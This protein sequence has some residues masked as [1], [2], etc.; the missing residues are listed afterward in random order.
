MSSP[1]PGAPGDALVGDAGMAIVERLEIER[2][3]EAFA[4]ARLDSSGL[5]QGDF[6]IRFSPG[7]ALDAAW[8]ERQFADNA[9]LGKPVPLDRIAALVQELSLA[10]VRNGYVNS[11]LL[12]APA[13]QLENGAIVLRLKL[14]SGRIAGDGR[15]NG[16]LVTWAD[17]KARGLTQGYVAAR[18]PAARA[19]PLDG[20]A[21]E[22][23][24]R[25]LANDPAIETVKADLLPGAS[26]GEARLSVLVTPAP[27]FE[28]Y[29]GI[30]NDRAPSV[31]GI[32]YAAGFAMRNL[33]AP[34]DRLAADGGLTAG[35]PDLSL[36]FRTPFATPGLALVLRGSANRAAV[37]DAPL[38][39]LAIRA[40]D[41]SVEGGIA[42]TLYARPLSPAADSGGAEISERSLVLGARYLHRETQTFLL[43][44][45][46]S[47]SPGSVNGRAAYDAAKVSLDWTERSGRAAWLFGLAATVGIDGT[48]SDVAGIPNPD[49]HFLTVVGQASHARRLGESGFELRARITG[50]ISNGP[51]YSGERFSAGGGQ[52]VRGY[53]EN[54]LLAD[55]G[56]FGSLELARPVRLGGGAKGPLGLEWGSFTPSLF[57][58][59]AAVHNRDTDLQP[60]PNAIASIGAALAWT[61]SPRLAARVSYG[62]ALTDVP[63]VGSRDLQDDGISFALT[64][65]V[66]L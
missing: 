44:I 26:P 16:L 31:G 41:W 22:R 56:L 61:P 54:Q 24:F 45:P 52:S 7:D 65:R 34:G 50:Q 5:P 18:M 9:M 64:Y 8:V 66:A 3:E 38:R 15:T 33:F 58:D 10:F 6:A 49:R 19:V 13:G 39:D 14:V 48:R 23:D 20:M 40:S 55:E 30:A 53:R 47:F 62:Y 17:G 4:I 28:A 1:A 36:D 25:S 37:V 2:D 27:R 63:V 32:R 29:T 12:L 51:V 46:F 21:L 11:G 60:D 57:V 35:R 59:G 42:A 43:G